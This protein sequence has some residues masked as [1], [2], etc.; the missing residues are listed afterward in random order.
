MIT[1]LKKPQIKFDA[2]MSGASQTARF[3]DLKDSKGKKINKDTIL[4]AFDVAFNN[5]I[6][7]STKDAADT[8]KT[9]SIVHTG[10]G[11]INEWSQYTVPVGTLGIAPKAAPT[12]DDGQD[13]DQGA[14]SGWAAAYATNGLKYIGAPLRAVAVAGN[15]KMYGG[16][17]PQPFIVHN[18]VLWKIPPGTAEMLNVVYESLICSALLIDDYGSSRTKGGGEVTAIKNGVV[19]AVKAFV[20]Y[21]G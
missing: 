9:L 13:W 21:D 17:F 18:E 7:D 14:K 8:T 11:S 4:A 20:N 12:A 5:I 19:D 16:Y 1:T 10:T 2:L 3:A 6:T 15:L